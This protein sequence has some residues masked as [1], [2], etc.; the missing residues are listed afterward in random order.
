MK[1]CIIIGSGLGGLST[2]VIL[3]K[4]G[5]DVTILE[6]ASQVGGCLQCFTRDGVK[7]ET[8]MHFI[9]SLDDGQVLSHYFNYLGIKDKVVLNR[10]DPK[11]Y[12]VVSLQGE[13]F[14]FPNG[15][16]AFIEKFA[17]RFPD[18]RENLEH[19]CDLVEQVASLSPFRDLQHVVDESRFIDDKLLYQSLSD[20]IDQTITDPLLREVLVGNLSLYAAQR[21][22]TPFATHAFIFDFYNSSA[23]RIVGGSDAIVKALTEVFEQH[24]GKVLTR[25]KVTKILVEGKKASGVL[26][27]NGEKF[28]ADVVISDVN[29]KQMIGMV[30]DG[31]F[32][33][34]YKS[35]I[36]G[37]AD[38][39]AVFSLFLRFK[40]GAMP[41]L[42]SNFYGFS[43]D[44]PW[45]MNGDIGDKWPQGY[46]YMHHCHEPNP[47]YARGGVVLAYMSMD[48][49]RNWSD[50]SIGHRGD[51]YERF[52]AHMAERLLDSVEKDFP[53]LRDAIEAYYAASPLTYRDYTS[54]PEGSIYGL[55][56]NVNNIADR[57]S[58]KTKVS[59]LLLVGQNIN[60]HGMLGVLVG[61][62][63]V[64]QHLLGEAKVRQQM[65]ESN[66]KSVVVIGGGLGGLVSGALLAKEGYKVTVLEKNAIIGGGLQTFKRKGVSFP[67][68]M[69]VFGGFGEEGQLR[70]LFSYLGIMDRL[71]LR[72]MDEEG[73]DVVKVLEDGASYSLP[74]GKEHFINYLGEVFP[75]EKANIRAYVDKLFALSEEE[76]LFYL[77]EQKPQVF[78]SVSEDAILPY[79]ELMDRYI[80]DQKLKGVLSYLNPLMGGKPGTTPAFMS[81]LLGVLHIGGTYQFVGS[82]QQMAELLKEVIETAGGQV[83][84]N[85]EV[86]RIEVEGREVCRV[87]TKQGNAYHADSYISDVHP[88]VLLRLV[89]DKAFPTLF[90]SRIQ[91]IP[92]TR[93]CF[94]VYV[95][96]KEGAFPYVNHTN[97]CL[98]DYDTKYDISQSEWP[99]SVMYY[100][101][102][103]EGQGS[104]A[105]TMVIISEM[106]YEW[107]KPWEASQ[108]GHRGA[109][110]EQWKLQMTEQVLDFMEKIYPD[111]REKTEFVMASSPLTI[112]DYYGNK[113]G[114]NYGFLRDSH[115]IMLS[116][117]SVFTKVKNLY[118]TGQNVNIHGMCGVALTAIQT[119]EALVG[120]NTVVRKINKR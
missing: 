34:A 22:K 54:T 64:C 93:S 39:T 48:A 50:T 16:D 58:Y 9:G 70:K 79:D 11:A 49:V 77:R 120:T 36:K 38:T 18:Q 7:F 55:E 80:T 90:R 106:D 73:Y 101:P 2:G 37:I 118:L 92:E 45:Q 40:E 35:R 74:K 71:S 91:S 72:A 95:K 87:I 6:Q 15:R 29:P 28:T 31:V 47:K 100:T 97:Y 43:T 76:D 14:A 103:V 117:L 32:T 67:T 78:M 44:S 115:N 12:D 26:T 116:Q 41:Y 53:G 24:G 81:A 21:G 109:S 96:F 119:V 102:A 4:N 94:K 19:Y 107:V 60:S 83:L 108:V 105:E 10:L 17:Q 63:N 113:E 85:E 86:V 30:D 5:Y 98:S 27:A 82:S 84:A 51:D 52:K 42:N 1:K 111:I 66:R 114:S 110:Y 68:G 33:Q 23:F 89:D 104:Y 69:H 20:V 112:R 62:M 59:N 13:R 46:L 99:N 57:V 88:D 56:K 25:R 65:M 8:G 3:A 75:S 61:T